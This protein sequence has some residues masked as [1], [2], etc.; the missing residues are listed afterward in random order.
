MR[1]RHARENDRNLANCL[2]GVSAAPGRT[3]RKPQPC[4]DSS[5]AASPACLS[6]AG[7]HSPRRKNE[8]HW[9]SARAGL[10]PISANLRIAFWRSLAYSAD[11]QNAA[12]ENWQV[13]LSLFPADWAE[14]AVGTGAV[15]RLR[16]FS[17]PEALLRTLLL[18]VARGYSLRETAVQ[19]KLAD[20][21]DVSDVA[22]LKRLRNSEL[23]L[24]TMCA[25]LLRENGVRM[26][27]IP[28]VKRMRIVDG[29]IV[30]EPGKTGSQ[31]RV[32][33]SLQLPDLACD[34]FQISPAEGAGNGESFTRLPVRKGDLILGD[35][36]YCSAGGIRSVCQS[37]G[38]VL[39]RVN[40][41]TF[42][43]YSV[44]GRRL[45]LLTRLRGLSEAGL[46]GDWPVQIRDSSACLAGRLCAIRKSEQ[47]IQAAHRRIELNAIRK[48]RKTKPHTW[49][50]AKYV[51][52]FTTET[53]A[54]AEEILEWYR[55]RWQIELAFKRLKSL[56][57]LGHLPKHDQHSSRAWLYGKLL[58][59]LLTRKLIRTARDISPWGYLFPPS[60]KPLA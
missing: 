50:Y 34:F 2:Y 25:D 29:T 42:V 26:Q 18:H 48:K 45:G 56:A 8:W 13:L 36:A 59:A 20:W 30:K 52:V 31:W 19:A 11:M 1:R 60:S 23:W 17:S 55:L 40:P 35:A 5:W 27:N 46:I 49:E 37:G 33:Y 7:Q 9:A 21:A 16:G 54:P 3:P 28:A 58:V 57:Q 47:A 51:V 41:S 43:A 39:V 4:A 10:E 53:A 14:E 15:E 44:Q 22:L 32:L 24:R 38:D 6:S 12:D